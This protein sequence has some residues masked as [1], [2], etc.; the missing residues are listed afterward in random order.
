MIA[1][2]LKKKGVMLDTEKQESLRRNYKLRF[3]NPFVTL[4]MAYDK[5][6]F[7]ILLGNGLVA[8]NMYAVPVGVTSLFGATYGFNEIQIALCFLPFGAGA[9]LSSFATGRLLDRNYKKHALRLGLP[10]VKNRKQDLKGFSTIERARLEVALPMVCAGMASMIAYGWVLKSQT[11]LAGPLVLLF[12]IGVTLTGAFQAMNIMMI[13][14]YPEKAATATAANNLF[15]CLLGAGATAILGPMLN[16]WGAG[17]TYTF[18]ALLWVV[19]S[20]ALLLLIKYGPEW[21]QERAEK[22]QVRK[23]KKDAAHQEK[24][25]NINEQ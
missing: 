22:D 20:P 24:Q 15:R 7:I 10:V 12:F 9:I 18:F 3:P 5:A 6:C 17:W 25:S 11:N 14:N 1:K 23:E 16:S 2:G 19:F 21:R 4:V 13:D 8:G